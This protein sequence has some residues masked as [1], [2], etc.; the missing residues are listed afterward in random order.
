MRGLWL[1]LAVNACA[2]RAGPGAQCAT[3]TNGDH[4]ERE[5]SQAAAKAVAKAAAARKSR[6]PGTV[7]IQ[8][9][10]LEQLARRR[11]CLGNL[12]HDL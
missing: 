11:A 12:C 5:R 8:V 2:V 6:R 10:H 9:Q 4:K 7:A 3:G 1:A